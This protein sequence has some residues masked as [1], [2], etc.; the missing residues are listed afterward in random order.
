MCREG[1]WVE[2]CEGGFVVANAERSYYIRENGKNK[3]VRLR[4]R[5]ASFFLLEEI[6]GLKKKLCVYRLTNH[7]WKTILIW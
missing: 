7:R 3:E 6:V 5:M 2:L 1:A 4:C